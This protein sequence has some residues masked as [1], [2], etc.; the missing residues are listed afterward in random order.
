MK[1]FTPTE[2]AD[3]LKVSVDT[4]LRK[5]ANFPGVIDLGT[6]ERGRKRQYRVLRIPDNVLEKFLL[7]VRVA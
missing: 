5:F 4:V 7:Q 6:P 2:V 1:F 3:M